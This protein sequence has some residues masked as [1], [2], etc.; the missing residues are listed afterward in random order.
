MTSYSF[1]NLFFSAHSAHVFAHGE[2]VLALMLGRTK[3]VF[4][5]ASIFH[6]NI[7]LG[8]IIV[9]TVVFGDGNDVHIGISTIPLDIHG[10]K[11][12][13]ELLEIAAG[14]VSMLPIGR[15]SRQTHCAQEYNPPS[16]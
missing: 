15:Y 14:P 11:Y 16:A 10:C 5:K 3:I 12:A 4:R 1:R 13:G 6:A 9:V 2:S 7:L 8:A